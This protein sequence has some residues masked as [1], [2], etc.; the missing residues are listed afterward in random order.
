M[1]PKR[2]RLTSSGGSRER[3]V[4]QPSRTRSGTGYASVAGSERKRAL[5]PMPP[6]RSLI[7][8]ISRRIGP[9][10]TPGATRP[11]RRRGLSKPSLRSPWSTSLLHRS[12]LA[13]PTRCRL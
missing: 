1:L 12:G 7:G 5:R 11:R 2:C 6:C 4:D 13:P 10:I 8:P 9:G 3:R